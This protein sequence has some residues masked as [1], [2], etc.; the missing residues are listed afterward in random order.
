MVA[1]VG[2]LLAVRHASIVLSD[3]AESRLS[4]AYTSIKMPQAVGRHGALARFTAGVVQPAACSTRVASSSTAAMLPPWA[5]LSRVRDQQVA[6][7]AR[8]EIGVEQ[9][10]VV[11]CCPAQP[12]TTVAPCAAQPQ[13]VERGVDR[14]SNSDG[15]VAAQGRRLGT[16][17]KLNEV[18]ATQHCTTPHGTTIRKAW[19]RSSKVQRFPLR[20]RKHK[21]VGGKGTA[22]ALL[23]RVVRPQPKTAER[24]EG[25]AF[26][27]SGDIG[28]QY[29]TWKGI[30]R[31]TYVSR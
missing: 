2:P 23:L 12:P 26:R 9:C 13:A 25:G 31:L 19:I 20:T 5:A 14:G 28:C 10:A 21:E 22:G 1:M 8:P 29:E 15:P 3:S 4:A 16:V 27:V 17:A 7:I 30:V 24:L 18:Q 11:G 6:A